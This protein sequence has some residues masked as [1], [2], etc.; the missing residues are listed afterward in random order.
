MRGH[1]PITERQ[2][3]SDVSVNSIN[4]ASAASVLH[5][6]IFYIYWRNTLAKT[7]QQTLLCTY[8]SRYLKQMK[9]SK[10]SM[11]VDLLV[12]EILTVFC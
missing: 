3:A 4:T 2:R 1:L 12:T 9:Q 6:Y 10:R 8:N 11:K 5:A 7:G